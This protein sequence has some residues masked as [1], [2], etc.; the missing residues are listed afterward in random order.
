MTE[1]IVPASTLAE[2]YAASDPK[3]SA[4]VSANAGSGKT[5]VLTQRVI[6]LML[7]GN[8]PDR[9][10]CLTF[11]KAA[12]ANMKNRVFSTL[13]RWTMLDE[14]RLRGEIRATTGVEAKPGT[15]R[16]ARRLFTDALDTPGGLKI[17]TIH[18]FCESLLHQFPLEANLSGHFDVLQDAV[19]AEMM[20][21]AWQRIFERDDDDALANAY[22]ALI[23][24]VSDGALHGGIQEII[25]R[26]NE[27]ESWIERSGGSVDDAIATLY[28]ALGI[29]AGKAGADYLAEFVDR[30]VP[31]AAYFRAVVAIAVQSD[32]PTDIGLAEGLC[33]WLEGGQGE[34]VFEALRSVCFT[35]KG[36][37]KSEKTLATKF[38]KEAMPEFVE[39]I[40]ELAAVHR[41]TG[42]KMA[43]LRLVMISR[44]LFTIAHAVL[45]T[46]ER[47]KRARG[48]LDYD[49]Q[50]W[51]TVTLLG[52][53]DIRDWIRFRLDRG[54]DHVLVD[55]AQDTSP[56]QWKIINAITEDFHAGK[57]S[58]NALRTVFVV[59]DEKQSIYSFQ[60][61][62]PREFD[63]Q[64]RNLARRVENARQEF[65]NAKLNLSFRSTQDVLKAVDRV[66]E[67]SNNARGLTRDGISPVH[68]AVR[69]KQPGEVQVWPLFAKQG[70]DKKTNWLDPV[71]KPGQGDPAVELAERI[72]ETISEWIGKPLP[73]TGKPLRYDDIL[74]LVRNRDRFITALTR[75]LKDKGHAVAGADR[76]KLLEH[77][78]VE[79]MLSAGKFVLLPD[80]DLNLAGLLK[81]MFFGLSEDMLFQL[82][83][84]RGGL[85]L[86]DRI[87]EIAGLSDHVAHACA[88][89]L[90]V[91]LETLR[92]R[93]LR[94]G[95]F[96]FYAWL[97][98][99]AGG[100]RK[101]LARLG[102]EAEDV[103]DAFLDEVLDFSRAGG[104]GLE[105]FVA[106]LSNADPEI[107]RELELERNEV[108]ILT[109]HASKGLEARVVF[110]VDSCGKAFE[111]RKRAKVMKLDQAEG[112]APLVWVPTQADHVAAS[113]EEEAAAEAAAD[114]EYRRLLYVGMTRAADRLV[115]CGYHGVN[116]PTHMHWHQMVH[117]ALLPGSSPLPCKGDE[118]RGFRW[119][120]TAFPDV[121]AQ[122]GDADEVDTSSTISRVP[123][124]LVQPVASEPSMPRPL[125]PSGAY[126]LIDADA[127]EPR[128]P[129]FEPVDLVLPGNGA[130][131]GLVVHRLLEVLPDL[132]EARREALAA[133]YLEKAGEG[134]SAGERQAVLAQVLQLLERDELKALFSGRGRAEVPVIGSLDTRT[135][136]RLISGQIDRLLIAEGMVHI[137]DYKTN[138]NVPERPQ[139]TPGEYVTQMALYRHLLMEAFVDH[140]VN[141]SILWTHTQH[142]MSLPDTMLDDA[143]SALKKA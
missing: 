119:R 51:K 117:D 2:Q 72:S 111:T 23:P 40:A 5:H 142:L 49:D 8:P 141:C 143:L 45:K 127:K 64:Q 128:R 84:D 115:L 80:D 35:Q 48:L 116:Q 109:V 30:L 118:D 41:E 3:H 58:S 78:A 59:G 124:W 134:W 95:V 28:P 89:E 85:C 25:N 66:F 96:D 69:E 22:A 71:D 31:L 113:L 54:I 43:A 112:I 27:F 94:L 46:Y 20:D 76:L 62:D 79:D 126:A 16:K 47:M 18:A 44:N 38:V 63:A 29:E 107:K 82:S 19:K 21:E 7:D 86:F 57:G 67:E 91:Q 130:E 120:H 68:D 52:R 136:T 37:L 12:A 13:S 56:A 114:A 1:I 65:R 15:L 32:K 123:D 97:L 4:W 77:V 73:G 100:R 6:R 83:H 93:G 135:G 74:V 81:S 24:E 14:T 121:L 42:D 9:I 88:N 34:A 138:R 36:E 132:P 70:S 105:G 140:R 98:G 125:T 131:H 33:V 122:T 133:R 92:E 39:R 87:T 90:L 53:T 108:R 26:R 106:R 75:K 61:A 139:D 101:I 10:L 17:Q 55:E 11:T 99:A 137:I 104:M 103:V 102:N 60:G 129:V 50:I 110:L